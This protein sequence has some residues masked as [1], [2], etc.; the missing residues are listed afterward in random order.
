MIFRVVTLAVLFS[1]NAYAKPSLTISYDDN[2]RKSKLLEDDLTGALINHGWQIT[3]LPMQSRFK[4]DDKHWFFNFSE[5][6]KYK[7]FG[8]C[9][10]LSG[11]YQANNTGEFRIST[12]EGSKS[13]CS[14]SKEEETMIFNLLLMIDHFE[15]KNDRLRFKSNGQDLIEL[16]TSH[17]LVDTNL[18][19]KSNENE[20]I[21]NNHKTKT[22]TKKSLKKI[23]T[24]H[25]SKRKSQHAKRIIHNKK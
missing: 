19:R 22:K 1:M 6:K 7:A 24:T 21:H 13:N 14:E 25:P 18:T 5:N 12:L 17:K 2:A 9:N 4:P 16:N 23:K 10:I 3:A 20:K 11:S 8:N 15:I